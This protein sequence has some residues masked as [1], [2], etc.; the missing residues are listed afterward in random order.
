MSLF[1]S[2]SDNKQIYILRNE[3][4]FKIF[5]IIFETLVRNG[6]LKHASLKQVLNIALFHVSSPFACGFRKLFIHINYVSI[7]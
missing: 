6:F 5:S 4:S 2:S 3:N 1:F 7:Y